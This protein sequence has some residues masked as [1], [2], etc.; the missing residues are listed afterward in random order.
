[1]REIFLSIVIL[2]AGCVSAP[3]WQIDGDKKVEITMYKSLAP[4][5]YNLVSCSSSKA[6]GSFRTH[7]QSGNFET[8]YFCKKIFV[9]Q[10]S[11]YLYQDKN[12]GKICF[13]EGFADEF[14][15]YLGG[16]YTITDCYEFENTGT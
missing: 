1:M 4:G 14:D 9:K 5:E 2:L 3:M 10:A 12:A 15:G 11:A 13:W 8:H 7:N 16:V 6:I